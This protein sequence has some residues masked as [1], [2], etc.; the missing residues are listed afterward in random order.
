MKQKQKV[1]V[2]WTIE[3]SFIRG[4]TDMFYKV[5]FWKAKF[6]NNT[7]FLYPPI[8]SFSGWKFTVLRDFILRIRT[9]YCKCGYLCRWLVCAFYGQTTCVG[10]K[11]TDAWFTTLKLRV[12]Y[13]TPGVFYAVLNLPRNKCKFSPCINNHLYSRCCL[14]HK[15]W[16]WI[17]QD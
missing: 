16:D 7:F 4:S 13:H 1:F 9:S 2:L 17:V 8:L 15:D 6:E 11:Y 5:Q 12:F 14:C 10:V 3:I